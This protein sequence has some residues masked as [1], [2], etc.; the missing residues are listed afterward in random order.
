[1]I[2]KLNP[3]FVDL[4]SITKEDV[5][6]IIEV[7]ALDLLT[8]K[9]IDLIAKYIYLLNKN[10]TTRSSFNE[11]LYLEH[12]KAFN[13]F[14][15]GDYSGKE[16]KE[17]FLNT[18]DSVFRFMDKSNDYMDEFII[19]FS[20]RDKILCDGAH[21]VS[22]AIF[23]K[24]KMKIMQLQRKTNSFDWAFFKKRGLKEHYLD[25]MLYN[26][27]KLKKN[28]YVF[29]IWP[30]AR[31]NDGEILTILNK[32]GNIIYRKN[33]LLNKRGAHNFIVHTYLQHPWVG[34]WENAYAGAKNKTRECFKHNK[35][36]QCFFIESDDFNSISSAKREIRNLFQ[37]ANSSGH[38]TDT[39]EETLFLSKIILNDNTIRFLNNSIP[40]KFPRFNLLFQRY[41]TA[42]DT[43]EENERERFC[44]DSSAVLGVHGI[45]DVGDLDYMTNSNLTVD[46]GVDIDNHEENMKY[47]DI[48]KEEIINN[49]DNHFYYM[50]IK[51]VSLQCLYEM[52]RK[53][54]EK[55]DRK[56]CLL[57]K[58][59]KY[60]P[61]I[62]DILIRIYELIKIKNKIMYLI[63]RIMKFA[64]GKLK[65]TLDCFRPFIRQYNYCGYSLFYSKGTSLIERIRE[66][67]AYEQSTCDIIDRLLKDKENP[68]VIDVGANIGLIS[69]H[70]LHSKKENATIY[71]FEPGE[72]QFS[73]FSRTIDK[74]NL[75]KKIHLS[76]IA[77]SNKTGSADFYVHNTKHVSGDGFYDTERAGTTKKVTV[78]TQTMDDWWKENNKVHVDFIKID[79]EGAELWVLEGARSIIS[80]CRPFI[81]TEMNSIN[82][83]N[84][85]YCEQE[86]LKVLTDLGYSVYNEND[87]ETTAT[88]LPD[89]QKLNIDTYYCVPK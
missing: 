55:K 44:I 73:L 87:E 53:R 63:K 14:G 70:I 67:G 21:R 36:L 8:Y 47:Y 28:I 30:S 2:D 71:A 18:F 25:Y 72:H 86:V 57:I 58:C 56:D 38:A 37:I 6:D 48:A 50:G 35:P 7:E 62:E 4:Y 79:T 51:F 19:P 45:R 75:A 60:M 89:F 46:F 5:V 52:K 3:Y 83:K 80:T 64:Y 81:V 34:S 82:Y 43:L 78:K 49:P 1:M 15:E 39:Y 54:G 16:G 29:C 26:Y 27:V 41:K 9:R 22:T 32:A 12:I 68:T 88:N 42:I 33:I 77:L 31:G 17:S 24:K 84:Y 10:E 76:D 69:L 85:P 74:N 23:L 40:C 59:N 66:T 65:K 20:Y 13:N 11:E 61:G